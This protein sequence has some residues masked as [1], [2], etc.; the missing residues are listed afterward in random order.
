MRAGLP[1]GLL[2]ALLAGAVAAVLAGSGAAGGTGP[3]TESIYVDGQAYQI[4]TN[5]ALVFDASPGLLEHSAPFFIIGFP[6]AAGTTGRITLPSGYQP[7]NNGQPSP[8]PYH[9]HTMAGAPGLGSGTA[10]DYTATFRV[11]ILQ[12]SW[13]YAYSPNFVPITSVAQIPAAEAAGKLQVTDPEASDP[14]QTWTT[15]VL[16]R[17]IVTKS[18]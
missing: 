18:N 7:Q 13:A 16:I 15:T 4:N 1:S 17:P 2:A 3:S 11:V 14:Y 6:V 9:D 10:G 8:I 12:Y 5:A